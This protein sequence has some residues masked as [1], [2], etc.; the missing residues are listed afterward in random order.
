MRQGGTLTGSSDSESGDGER[1]GVQRWCRGGMQAGKEV[2]RR[3]A[4][5][6][7]DVDGEVSEQQRQ[8]FGAGTPIYK[9]NSEFE[10]QLLQF[11]INKYDKF[12]RLNYK[13][14]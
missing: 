11:S 1:R 14:K 8:T 9:A 12:W 3:E 13:L 5:Q 10:A 6:S 7:V 2:D 4:W